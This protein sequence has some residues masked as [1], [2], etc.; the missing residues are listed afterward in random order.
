MKRSEKK[1]FPLKRLIPHLTIVLSVM[2][3]VFF[4]IDRYNEIMAFMTSEMSKWL[5]AILAV[6]SI[7]TSVCLIVENFREDDRMAAKQARMERRKE[8]ELKD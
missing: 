1:R 3:L 6:C 7:V 2:T 5:F 8:R 4:I